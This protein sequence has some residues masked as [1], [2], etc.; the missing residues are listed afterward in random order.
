MGYTAPGH[1]THKWIQARKRCPLKEKGWPAR[2]QAA[3]SPVSRIVRMG[4]GRAEGIRDW[5]PGNFG[6][7]CEMLHCRSVAKSCLTLCDHINSR[8]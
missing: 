8:I 3:S 2:K 5:M 6:H 7:S 4:E 1:H